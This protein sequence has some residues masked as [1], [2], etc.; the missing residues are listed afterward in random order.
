MSS[1]VVPVNFSQNSANAARYAADLALVIGAD[2]HLLYV[3]QLPVSMSEVPMP[4]AAY[5]SFRDSGL[6]LLNRLTEELTTRSFGK[7]RITS[8]M[9][10]GAIEQEIESFCELKKPF[11]VV[12][13]ASANTFENLL[14]G[15][16]TIKALRH[17]RYPVLV[18]PA[19]AKFKT[20]RKIVIACDRD[21]I[22]SGM[23]HAMPF[24]RE[25]SRLLGSQLEVV[26]A[27]SQEESATEAS[28]EYN[29]WK[30][31]V[32]ILDPALHLISRPDLS[33][34]L[35][36]YLEKQEAD[37][38]MVSPKSHSFLEFHRSRSKQL[39]NHCPIPLISLH[40]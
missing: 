17:L 29:K 18:V 27:L 11:L 32:N 3:F 28:F 2:V 37:W 10:T 33:H 13:G 5:D 7:V 22:D 30:N 25:L 9:Q 6:D 12:M 40:E 4:E 21:D 8:L 34:G 23:P 24:L 26:H 20:I 35:T 39:A 14:V 15:S 38:L 1:I 31:D 36:S 16:S 19:N